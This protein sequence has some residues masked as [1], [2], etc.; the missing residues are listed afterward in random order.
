[1]STEVYRKYINIINENSQNTVQLDEGV[2]DKLKSLVE[3]KLMQML[4]ADQAAEI[5]NK[6]KQVTG[7]DITPSKE[8]AIKVAQAFGF[9]KMQPEAGDMQASKM[10]EGIAGNWQGKLIQSLYSVGTIGGLSMAGGH[11]TL[12]NILGLS[13][14]AGNSIALIGFVLLMMAG[15]VF[16]DERGS[17]GVMGRDGNKGFE[18]GK[19]PM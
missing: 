17:V 1:M 3:P 16:G 14:M 4:G 12:G 5:A 13:S 8:N 6:V 10:T 9:D 11:S 15:A 2:M 7:G 19:G 18:T